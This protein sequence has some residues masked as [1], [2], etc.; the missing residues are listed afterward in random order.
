MP[1]TEIAPLYGMLS[2]EQQRKAIA[3]A[4]GGRRRVV[5]ATP[6]AET[7]LTIE[8]VSC[9]VDSGLCRTMRYDPSSGLSRLVTVPVSLD[10]AAQRSGRAGR[11]GPGVCYRLWSRAAEHRMRECREPEI[12]SADLAPTLLVDHAASGRSLGACRLVVARSRSCR[13]CWPHHSDG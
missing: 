4:S 5:L 13:S 2:P 3:P 12:M 6:V 7:S 11:L 8:G 1:D 10:M 9:V